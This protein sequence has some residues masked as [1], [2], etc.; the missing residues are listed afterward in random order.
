MSPATTWSTFARG[1]EATIVGTGSAVPSRLVTNAELSAQL[2]E[3]IDAFVRGTLVMMEGALLAP[4]RGEP[5]R[6]VETLPHA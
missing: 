5:V 1:R 4:G 3:D 6:F 2:G